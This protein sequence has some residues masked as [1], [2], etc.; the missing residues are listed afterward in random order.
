MKKNFIF[1]LSVLL[2][3]SLAFAQELK[4]YNFNKLYK[5]L[6][7]DRS[8][9][10][11]SEDE[12]YA[13]ETYK[14]KEDSF[15]RDINAYLRAFPNVAYDWYSVSPEES[16][17]IVKNLDQYFKKIPS[18]PSDIALYR[19]VDLKYRK[20]KSFTSG[21]E[22]IEKGYL[23][24]STSFKVADYFANQINDNATN[25]SRKAIFVL[26]STQQPLKAILIDQGE[27]EALLNH[28]QKIRIMIVKIKKDYDLYL[29]QICAQVCQKDISKEAKNFFKK[30]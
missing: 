19:G 3:S 21:E 13:L 9:F 12:I 27:D 15:Y 18:I 16:K 25:G 26:Y 6:S 11:A 10:S 24:T 2:V 7:Y 20:N 29:A 1:L 22:F 28:S 17:T 30:F 23:S 8:D 14:S 4:N 5:E